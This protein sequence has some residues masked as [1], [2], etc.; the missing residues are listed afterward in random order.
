MRFF[1]NFI[2]YL[3]TGV[4][5]DHRS[6]RSLIKSKMSVISKGRFLNLFSYT[7]TASV[8]AAAGGALQTV[9][10]D[11]S[12]TYLNWARDNMKL[13]RLDSSDNSFIRA[14]SFEFL[15]GN[16]KK[17]NLIF[18]DPPTYSNGSGRSDWSVQEDHTALITL[19]MKNLSSDGSLLF[20]E[21]FRRFR[22]DP[23]L[24]RL[25]SVKE[26]TRETTDPDFI[27]RNGAYRCWD[28]SHRG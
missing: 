5:L 14:D 28:I 11:I 19:A 10:V 6:I 21:N 3:D 1:V 16:N 9:S 22:L 24:N 23:D 20:S 15:E 13:N 17:F 27:R 25:F 18:I 26:I 2:D 8:M 7:G 4:F 12:N